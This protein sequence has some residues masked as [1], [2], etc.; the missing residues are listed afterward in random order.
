MALATL[1]RIDNYF[2]SDW[3]PRRL[4]VPRWQWP[5]PSGSGLTTAG[6]AVWLLVAFRFIAFGYT[7]GYGV[8]E[9]AR[10]CV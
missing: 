3:D 6:P 1:A 8:W 2:W 4:W 9:W 10:G 5:S 7:F